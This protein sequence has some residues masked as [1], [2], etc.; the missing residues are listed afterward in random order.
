MSVSL[1]LMLVFVLGFREYPKTRDFG[2]AH[3]WTSVTPYGALIHSCHY[4]VEV[5][6]CDGDPKVL[7]LKEEARTSVTRICQAQESLLGRP[8]N[9]SHFT[10]A[11]DLRGLLS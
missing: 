11:P 1:P 3:A 9:G 2:P 10:L 4:T 6:E 7:W 5:I 8:D